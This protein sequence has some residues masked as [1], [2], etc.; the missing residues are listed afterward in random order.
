MSKG[1][2]AAEAREIMDTQIHRLR[3]LPYAELIGYLEPVALEVQAPS[4]RIFQI[5]IEAVWDDRKRQ[6][7]R[8][9]VYMDDGTGM[10]FKPFLSDDFIVA[11][12]GGFI[13]E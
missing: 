7:L 8:V 10:R 1:V 9:M 11:S 4:G 5:E 13:G 3:T 12:D 2:V 6:H